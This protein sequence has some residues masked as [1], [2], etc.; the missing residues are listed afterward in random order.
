MKTTG[1]LLLWAV[2]V[3]LSL[4]VRDE[5]MERHKICSVKDRFTMQRICRKSGG[6]LKHTLKYAGKAGIGYSNRMLIDFF[7]EIISDCCRPN[8]CTR[9]YLCD[10]CE[11]SCC[12]I[13]VDMMIMD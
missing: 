5:C 6:L 12:Q 3:A 7:S 13:A 1:I 4:S 11:N 2:C 9:Q 10:F 8:G